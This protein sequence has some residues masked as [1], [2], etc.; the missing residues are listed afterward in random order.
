[1]IKSICS[2]YLENLF[3]YFFFFFCTKINFDINVF[4]NHLLITGHA[5]IQ[6]LEPV[7]T[8]GLTIDDVPKLKNEI[9]NIMESAYKELS[10]EVLSALP[11]NYPLATQD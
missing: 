5:I 3:N 2:Y 1:M 9:Q 8:V 7:P 4:T 10:K 6:C 11:P